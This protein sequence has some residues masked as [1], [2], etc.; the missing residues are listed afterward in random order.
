M[1]PLNAY[2]IGYFIL[3]EN[4]WLENYYQPLQEEFEAFLKRNKNGEEA[5][6]IVEAERREIE[7]YEKDKDYYSYGF[8]IARKTA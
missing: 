7:L 4:C 5:R 6:R 8:Y 1:T 2:P 3:P